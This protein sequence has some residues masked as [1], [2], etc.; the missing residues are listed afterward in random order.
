MPRA[1]KGANLG[2]KKDKKKGGPDENQAAIL[3]AARKEQSIKDKM[4][5]EMAAEAARVEEAAR[6]K[7]AISGEAEEARQTLEEQAALRSRGKRA[8]DARRA[9]EAAVTE[10]QVK[11]VAA[12]QQQGLMTAQAKT[13]LRLLNNLNW[14]IIQK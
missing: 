7:A 3:Y 11:A 5:A 4:Q 6:L 2:K 12:Q 1:K 8:A 9:A 13:F 14:S 10:A